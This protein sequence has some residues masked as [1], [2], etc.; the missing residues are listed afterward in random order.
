MDFVFC[1]KKKNS[2]QTRNRF[3][4]FFELMSSEPSQVPP[5]GVHHMNNTQIHI[6]ISDSWVFASFVCRCCCNVAMLHCFAMCCISSMHTSYFV[7]LCVTFQS[8]SVFCC[9]F[10]QQCRAA[11]AWSTTRRPDSTLNSTLCSMKMTIIIKV[12]TMKVS[13]T[14]MITINQSQSQQ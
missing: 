11:W 10:F 3:V 1:F 9:C 4:L 2:N 14:I 12:M 13:I 8:L 7:F 5:E 6:A